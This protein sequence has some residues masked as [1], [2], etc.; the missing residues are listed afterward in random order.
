MLESCN[1]TSVFNSLRVYFNR[2]LRFYKTS[3]LGADQNH[4]VTGGGGIGTEKTGIGVPRNRHIA[5]HQDPVEMVTTKKLMTIKTTKLPKM[6]KKRM[7][8]NLG[9]LVTEKN[10]AGNS[11]FKCAMVMTLFNGGKIRTR[12]LWA[13]QVCMCV[14]VFSFCFFFL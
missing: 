6:R 1:Y 2:L 4:L 9:K 3:H 11:Y 5:L 7:A 8:R 14:F 10:T 13:L 12:Y